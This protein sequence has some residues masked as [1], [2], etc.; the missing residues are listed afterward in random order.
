MLRIRLFIFFILAFVFQLN[1]IAQNAIDEDEV[2]YETV[3]DDPYVINQLYI[4]VQPIYG[5]FFTTNTNIG[6]GIE[7]DY[8]LKD[9][10]DF[11]INGRIPYG[12]KFDMMRDAAKKNSDACDMLRQIEADHSASRFSPASSVARSSSAR[13]ARPS[14]V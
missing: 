2:I 6:F 12:T 3:Y 13:S 5:E 1:S 14:R 7:A 9:V 8:F 4:Q 11:N 10:F